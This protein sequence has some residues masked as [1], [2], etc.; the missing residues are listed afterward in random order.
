MEVIEIISHFISKDS[1]V[2]RV[3]FRC[4]GDDPDMVR[5]DTMEYEL[6]QEYGYDDSI[7]FDGFY[8]E[9]DEEEWDYEDEDNDEVY[10]DEDELMEFLNEYY[11]VGG[12][13]PDAEY[14]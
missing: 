4:M 13:L 11:V 12:K 7:S 6:L 8:S 3:E 9:F 2:L 5:T 10:I 14:L 1:N